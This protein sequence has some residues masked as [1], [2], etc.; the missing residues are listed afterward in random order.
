MENTQSTWQTA[1]I[2]IA[3]LIFA[4]VFLMA[5]SF[6][7]MDMG[8]T[9][10][11]IA[12]AGFPLPLFLAWCAAAL[13]AQLVIAFLSGAFFTPAAII[14][15]IYVI[16]LGFSF[17]GPSH[18]AGNQAEFGFFVDHFTFVAGLLFAAVHGPGSVLVAPVGR[19]ARK[20]E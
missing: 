3:R 10:G 17:H 2:L 1:A 14:A 15:A 20:A 19:P 16:F 8:A 11:Y 7:F 9:A 18:W 5:V 4:S 13:E 12:A 6:K